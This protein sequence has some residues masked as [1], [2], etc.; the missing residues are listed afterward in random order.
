MDIPGDVATAARII[1]GLMPDGGN[2]LP[3]YESVRQMDVRQVAGGLAT[4]LRSIFAAIRIKYP[5]GRVCLTKDAGDSEDYAGD[6]SDLSMS[7]ADMIIYKVLNLAVENTPSFNDDGRI[8]FDS[9]ALDET[10]V[11]VISG[12]LWTAQIGGS[13]ADFRNLIRLSISECELVLWVCAAHEAANFL[14]MMIDGTPLAEEASQQGKYWV[15]EMIYKA[16]NGTWWQSS[17]NGL[18]SDGKS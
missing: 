15:T 7:V 14:L 2:L 5:Y 10:A 13:P 9:S 4:I 17:A 12:V 16:E 6:A 11:G 3:D 8:K 18:S 1:E